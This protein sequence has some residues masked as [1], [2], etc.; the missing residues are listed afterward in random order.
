[1]WDM[2]GVGKWKMKRRIQNNLRGGKQLGT[3]TIGDSW[4]PWYQGEFHPTPEFEEVRPLFDELFMMPTS[5]AFEETWAKVNEPGVF[6]K[7]L[8]DETTFD[9]FILHVRKDRF[10]LRILKFD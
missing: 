1:M 7:S 3:L 8:H 2:W 10:L 4:F 5:D 9:T 6:L